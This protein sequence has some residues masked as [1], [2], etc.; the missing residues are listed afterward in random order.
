MDRLQSSAY[1]EC[2]KTV[3]NTN[4]PWDKL[5][6]KTVL[7]TGASGL[8]GTF[9]CDVLMQLND[10][11]KLN[12]KVIAIGR[13][14][15]K[16]NK[17]F[18]AYTDNQIFISISQDVTKTICDELQNCPVDYIFH[19]ASNTHPVSYA[20]QPIATIVTNVNGT[21]NLLSFAV[22][23]GTKRFVFASSVEVYGENRGDADCFDEKY[24]GYIDSNTLRAG[25]PESK[26]V[27]EALCQSY[28]S[29]KKLDVVI[30][31]LSR[32][33]GPTMLLSDTKALS[34]FIKN[35]IEQKDIIL[36]SEGNQF[37]SYTY[38]ADAVSALLYCMFFGNCGEAYNIADKNSNI[39][40]KDLAAICADISGT[41]VLF[42]KP[43]DIEKSG[44]SKATKAVLNAVKLE[45][46]GW[47][48][49]W[50]LQ[51]G[52]EKTISILRDEL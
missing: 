13:S 52:L 18:N 27:C 37:Y 7:V 20:T 11:I 46:L 34:Q 22:E 8:I 28:I 39:K 31:R 19:L 41:K 40:L 51:K 17:R 47:S 26:R 24:C 5:H 38:V 32:V 33:Y 36:K 35:A 6:D 23:H 1:I 10:S 44:F 15:E 9:L 4:L 25:Y 14:R 50:N 42:E 49:N 2:L 3:I 48:A 29:E 12:C 16:L 30:P 45:E 43:N 21:N